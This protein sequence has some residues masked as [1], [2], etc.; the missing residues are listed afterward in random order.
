MIS[1][2]FPFHFKRIETTQFA[3]STLGLGGQCVDLLRRGTS[4]LS[5]HLPNHPPPQTPPTHTHH[6]G[7]GYTTA[8]LM[9][10]QKQE[11]EKFQR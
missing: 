2:Y 8:G 10:T 11:R 7:R 4:L 5:Y 9:P 6:R 1:R 3:Q